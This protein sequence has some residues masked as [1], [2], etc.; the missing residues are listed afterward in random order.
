LIREDLVLTPTLLRRFELEAQFEGGDGRHYAL[1]RR[2]DGSLLSHH[3]GSLPAVPDQLMWADDML[4]LLNRELHHDGA[5]VVCFTHIKPQP[6]DCVLY[7]PQHGDYGRYCL[8]WL[9]QDGDP[10]FTQQWM[11]GEGELRDFADVI[12]AGRGSTAQKC[13]TSWQLW[14]EMM[15]KVLAP[16]EGQTFKRA[17]GQRA[18][19]TRH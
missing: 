8:I 5:W 7:N 1:I 17:Q 4:R 2:D 6:I 9:D 14:H 18:P 19:S 15:R 11:E 12:L 13:E 3:P 10:Q 16:K